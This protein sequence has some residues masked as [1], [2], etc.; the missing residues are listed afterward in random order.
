[1]LR[2]ARI[3]PL[4]RQT[5]LALAAGRIGIGIAALTATRPALR[6]AGFPEPGATGTTVAKT[7]GA[8]DLTLGLLTVA[9]RDD[10]A[11]LRAV[12]FGAAMLDGADVVAFSLAAAEPEARRAALVSVATAAGAALAGLW[13]WRRLG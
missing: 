11:A 3:D 10:R 8:R 1:M 13:A 9:A 12:T 6:A 5:S 7:L 2:A 4:A